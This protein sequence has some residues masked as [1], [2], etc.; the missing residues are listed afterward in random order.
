[1]NPPEQILILANAIHQAG[2]TLWIV[3]GSVRDSYLGLIPQDWDLEVYGLDPHSL[4][5]ILNKLGRAKWV[6]KSFSVFKTNIEGMTLDVAIPMTN[7][8]TTPNISITDAAK[9][10]DLTIN[11]I[12]YDPIKKHHVDPFGGRKDIEAQRLRYVDRSTF[13]RDPLRILRVARFTSQFEFK[14]SKDLYN[15]CAQLSLDGVASERI[16]QELRSIWLKSRKP[17]AG[18]RFLDAVKAMEKRFPQWVYLSNERCFKRVDRAVKAKVGLAGIDAAMMWTSAMADM[19]LSEGEMLLNALNIKR[20]DGIDMHSL[21]LNGMKNWG[22]LLSAK[23]NA[24]LFR[25][26]D[27]IELEYLIRVSEN[28]GGENLCLLRD[29]IIKLGISKK[30]P[31]RLLRGQDLFDIGYRGPEIGKAMSMIRDLQLDGHIRS[32]EEALTHLR[33]QQK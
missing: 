17:S 21:I 15:L 14:P 25:L 31:P 33:S 9:R 12:A 13:G 7:G 4:K 26:S 30:A 27:Q 10:R 8:K 23:T 16:E 1:M 29:K 24:D 2:G 20:F 11:A 18:L 5:L 32:K 6:G 19:S 22:I 3:G 28:I